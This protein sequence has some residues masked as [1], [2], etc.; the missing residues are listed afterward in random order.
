MSFPHVTNL[1]A[2]AAVGCWQA[3]APPAARLCHRAAVAGH[4]ADPKGHRAVLGA[5]KRC[6]INPRGTPHHPAHGGQLPAIDQ[7]A[8]LAHA[9]AAHWKVVYT[10]NVQLRGARVSQRLY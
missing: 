8:R 5:P 1:K 4:R 2:H 6:D 7:L 10:H 9:V 3:P